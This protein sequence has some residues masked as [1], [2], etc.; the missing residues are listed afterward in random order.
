[1]SIACCGITINNN[2]IQVRLIVDHPFRVHGEGVLWLN[3]MTQ[4]I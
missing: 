3:L 4:K 2:V 1:M